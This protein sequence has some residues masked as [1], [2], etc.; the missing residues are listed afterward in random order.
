MRGS[1]RLPYLSIRG[2]SS[3]HTGGCLHQSIDDQ[4]APSSAVARGIHWNAAVAAEPWIVQIAAG[5]VDAH[6]LS[7]G[8]LDV[9]EPV[10]S[11]FG[12][13]VGG[14]LDLKADEHVGRRLQAKIAKIFIERQLRIRD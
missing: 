4:F 11:A 5:P 6:A 8:E 9:G 7:V 10:E 2:R 3:A 13:P 12:R 1:S 14:P